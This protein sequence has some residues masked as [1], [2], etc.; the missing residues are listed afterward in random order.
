MREDTSS[1]ITRNELSIKILGAYTRN[2]GLGA[3][4]ILCSLASRGDVID[5]KSNKRE[6]SL[7]FILEEIII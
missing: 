3:I 5:I 4:G 2:V 6:N 1:I 7:H